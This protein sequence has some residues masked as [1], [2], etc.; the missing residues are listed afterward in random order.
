MQKNVWVERSKVS[1]NKKYKG[2]LFSSFPDLL[3]DYLHEWTSELI[4]E[5]IIEKDRYIL[6]LGCGYGRV[7]LIIREKFSAP[8]LIGL[9][10]SPYYI[11]EY[12]HNIDNSF[13]VISDS[14]YLPFRKGFFDIIFEVYSLTYLPNKEKYK[15]AIREMF[16][17]LNDDGAIL[18]IENNRT[19]TCFLNGFGIWSF[20]SRIVGRKELDQTKGILFQYDEIDEMA[21]QN[22]G[23]VIK[24]IGMPFFTLFV[25]FSICLAFISSKLLRI[26]LSVIRMLDKKFQCLNFL[27]FCQFYLIKKNNRR[28]VIG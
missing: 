21:R 1:L 28:N 13:S 17:S 10:I 23:V 18:I 20:L 22:E 16:Y 12:I 8:F 14:V 24:K 5:H 2:V 4:T 26:F 6:D 25:H 27:S 7:S 15:E 11:K 19:G 3:N 9:D